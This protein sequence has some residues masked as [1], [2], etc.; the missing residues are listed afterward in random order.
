MGSRVGHLSPGNLGLAHLVEILRPH[1]T[2][3]I[4]DPLD[5]GGTLGVAIQRLGELALSRESLIAPI[6]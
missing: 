3:V 2:A 4:A 6:G 1:F 5:Q